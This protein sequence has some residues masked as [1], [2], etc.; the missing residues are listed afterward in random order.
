MIPLGIT[1][2][3]MNEYHRNHG[4]NH[5]YPLHEEEDEH[6]LARVY[7]QYTVKQN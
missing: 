6:I 2:L 5:C 1:R 4:D 7:Y 3:Q